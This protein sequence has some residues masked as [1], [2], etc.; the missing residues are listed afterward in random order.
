MH[1]VTKTIQCNM[2]GERT[3]KQTQIISSSFKLPALNKALNL[4]FIRQ[5]SISHLETAI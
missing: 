3:T 5:E 2:Q 4:L 1:I